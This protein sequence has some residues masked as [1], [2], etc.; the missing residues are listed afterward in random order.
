MESEKYNE[1]V[2]MTKKKQTHRYREQANGYQ[3]WDRGKFRGGRVGGTNYR[4]YDR[5]QG[6]IIPRGE[7][8]QYFIITVIGTYT[9]KLVKK[10][11]VKKVGGKLANVNLD[12]YKHRCSQRDCWL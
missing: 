6:C 9:L 12:F 8:I 1:L 4:G 10:N 5:L 7:Y 11:K 3:W 2:N